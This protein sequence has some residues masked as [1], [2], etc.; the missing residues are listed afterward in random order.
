MFGIIF[1][2][3]H[4]QCISICMDTLFTQFHTHVTDLFNIQVVLVM[5]GSVGVFDV[6]FKSLKFL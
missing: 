6:I 1:N 3:Y 2:K 5:G 4:Y